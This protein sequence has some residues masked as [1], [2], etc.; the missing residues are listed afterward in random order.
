MP[1]SMRIGDCVLRACHCLAFC[2][3][4]FGGFDRLRVACRIRSRHI[5][6]HTPWRACA[7]KADVSGRVAE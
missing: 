4:T 5:P 6:L 1:R 7:P 3:P 2:G